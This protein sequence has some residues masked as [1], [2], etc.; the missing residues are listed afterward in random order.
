MESSFHAGTIRV[1]S[2]H[3]TTL[4]LSVTT[5]TLSTTAATTPCKPSRIAARNLPLLSKHPA[6]TGRSLS[7]AEKEQAGIR[8]RRSSGKSS[9]LAADKIGN[10]EGTEK[11]SELDLSGSVP[12]GAVNVLMKS[13]SVT[14]DERGNENT[15]ASTVDSHISTSGCSHDT[16]ADLEARKRKSSVCTNGEQWYAD[17]GNEG[18]SGKPN[19][20]KTD[21]Q[22]E[23]GKL[24]DNLC[25]S[26]ARISK[27]ID[28]LL[29]VITEGHHNSENARSNRTQRHAT[30][31]EKKGNFRRLLGIPEYQSPYTGTRDY[32]YTKKYPQ[33]EFG[34]EA[35]ENARVWKVYLDE[36]EAFD[37]EMLK[38]FRDTL[39]ALLV[40]VEEK[41]RRLGVG[42]GFTVVG[43]AV[44]LRRGWKKWRATGTQGT[45]AA[46]LSAAKPPLEPSRLLR[47]LNQL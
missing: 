32:D 33:D 39:D 11:E 12:T 9:G 21:K 27:G 10:K 41:G 22:L 30:E 23:G 28:A 15:I 36:A 13:G 44:H 46:A 3:I 6:T 29:S 18:V 14:R 31:T 5:T 8:R 17:N 34:E 42:V 40:F 43:V 16:Q 20:P 4:T 38:G 35:R 1:L 24:P 47:I 25:D 2:I 19:S 45:P 7:D 37:D 26:V